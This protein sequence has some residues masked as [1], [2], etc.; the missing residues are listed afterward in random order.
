MKT[1]NT[2]TFVCFV[3]VRG[4][5]Y[6]VSVTSSGQFTTRVNGAELYAESIAALKP[7]ISA[8]FREAKIVVAIP[9]TLGE[10][11]ARNTNGDGNDVTVDIVLT[12]IHG[13]SAE[14][15]YKRA[16]TGKAGTLRA[17]SDRE[18]VFKP[19][20]ADERKRWVELKRAEEKARHA[21][22]TFEA[23]RK[24][25]DARRMV[26]RE[27]ERQRKQLAAEEGEA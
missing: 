23:T 4:K 25:N 5:E 6:R 11:Y 3:T 26:E 2:P 20:S 21:R 8:Q 1:K 18:I 24:I 19:L 14:V 15:Q 22:E 10:W 13:R 17:Y 27:I 12:G 16:D 9:A 7:K